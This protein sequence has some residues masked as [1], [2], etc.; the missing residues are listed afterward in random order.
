MQEEK[1]PSR[2]VNWLFEHDVFGPEPVYITTD[3]INSYW[4]KNRAAECSATMLDGKMY[5]YVHMATKAYDSEMRRLADHIESRPE[6]NALNVAITSFEGKYTAHTSA[7]E[8]AG[9]KILLKHFKE[10]N[11]AFRGSPAGKFFKMVDTA[12]SSTGEKRA[13]ESMTEQNKRLKLEVAALK[14]E[15]DEWKTKTAA[16]ENEAIACK[17]KSAAAENEAIACKAK[18]QIA[19]AALSA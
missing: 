15:I 9:M 8:N 18:I 13:G 10:R 12:A 6:L 3:L 1:A 2:K 7:A 16:A 11:P 19:L 4:G 5:T 14:L 17:E